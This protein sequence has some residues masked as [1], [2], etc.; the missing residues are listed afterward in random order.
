M[1]FITSKTIVFFVESFL[2]ILNALLSQE[3]WR[4]F[5]FRVMAKF[6]EGNK[7]SAK[8]MKIEIEVFLCTV[9]MQ[10][11]LSFC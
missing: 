4:F 5:V 10:V 6:S 3:F 2:K 8:E 11:T 9:N 1:F 7:A